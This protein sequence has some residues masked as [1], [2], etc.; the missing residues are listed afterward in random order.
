MK[1]WKKSSRKTTRGLRDVAATRRAK[2]KSS[3]SMRKILRSLRI[4]L[5]SRWSA[6]TGSS[7]TL[8]PEPMS[9]SRN[10]SV[11]QNPRSHAIVNQPKP[12]RSTLKSADV[13]STCVRSNSTMNLRGIM[14][15][16]IRTSWSRLRS[17]SVRMMIF[18]FHCQQLVRLQSPPM[19]TMTYCSTTS[20]LM[21]S[22]LMILS[23]LA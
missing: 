14:T 5:E 18:L 17:F 6:R 7:V 23:Q 2:S 3:E 19:L 1:K 20:M 12:S 11:G 9:Q 8:N 4:T 21:K 13:L 10:L 22:T 15:V 16:R